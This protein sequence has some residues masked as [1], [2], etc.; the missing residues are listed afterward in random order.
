MGRSGRRTRSA[1]RCCG[2][3]RARSGW[4]PGSARRRN[5]RG[6]RGPARRRRSRRGDQD[7]C[8]CADRPRA[9]AWSRGSRGGGAWRVRAAFGRRRGGCS[10]LRRR[11]QAR[12]RPA[13]PTRVR[14]LGVV[15]AA[16]RAD[17][18][19]AGAAAADR[20]A[21]ASTRE[22]PCS[23]GSRSG[24]PGI[25]GR[26]ATA[27]ARTR[28]GRCWPCRSAKSSTH[29][30]G[31]ATAGIGPTACSRATRRG[32]HDRCARRRPTA[33]PGS[34]RPAAGCVGR[35]ASGAVARSAQRSAAGHAIR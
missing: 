28:R 31:A 15:V 33:A 5:V 18:R 8:G 4:P 1:S 2:S 7:R 11:G 24:E 29:R 16:R 23:A 30:R 32:S 6:R 19:A 13:A 12:R 3:T 9:A 20:A 34:R 21:A 10:A 22:P 26:R 27:G 35:A 14:A 25:A 17:A